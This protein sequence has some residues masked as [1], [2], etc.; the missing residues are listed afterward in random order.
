MKTVLDKYKGIH[1]GLILNHEL[2]K[3]QIPKLRFAEAVHQKRQILNE[4]TKGRRKLP[5]ELAFKIDTELDFTEG[6]MLMMQTYYEIENHRKESSI[7]K[8][9]EI[10]KHLRKGL[11]WD[12]D[13]NKLDFEKN[14]IAIIKR[15]FE[16][17]NEDEKKYLFA[18][19]GKSRIDKAV[20]ENPS[21]FA[22][23]SINSTSKD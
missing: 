11:F 2:K 12:T 8:N 21:Y 10:F 23:V 9:T 17:G 1:P 13:V 18:Y 15:I 7:P 16:R 20:N 19:Y 22:N 14:A 6:T 4:I 5:V 3:R